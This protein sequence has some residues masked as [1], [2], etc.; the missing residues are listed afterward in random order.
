[1][2]V[3]HIPS[4]GMKIISVHAMEAYRIVEV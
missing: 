2:Y 1:M 4:A 3:A